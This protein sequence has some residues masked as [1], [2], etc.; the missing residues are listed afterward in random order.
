MKDKIG[1]VKKKPEIVS[2]YIKLKSGVDLADMAISINH[3]KR[4]TKKWWKSIFFYLLD[5][6]LHN[7]SII[8]AYKNTN[9]RREN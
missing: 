3:T 8:Y 5:I 9:Y 4:K 6:H 2:Y 1:I 7:L